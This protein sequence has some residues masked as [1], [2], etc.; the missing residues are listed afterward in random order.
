MDRKLSSQLVK[1]VTY[2]ID[3]R[4]IKSIQVIIYI[5]NPKEI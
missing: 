4:V 1:K 3:G 2:L 5:V